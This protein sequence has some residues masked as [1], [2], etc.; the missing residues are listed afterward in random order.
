MGKCLVEFIVCSR[1]IVHE[2]KEAHMA[3]TKCKPSD[4]AYK[5]YKN[6]VNISN[7][8]ITWDSNTK[9]IM[10]V[11]NMKI[12]MRKSIIEVHKDH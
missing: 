12:Y 3:Y 6:V 5:P 10:T 8:N 9:T 4:V 7:I 2:R 1:V 11:N